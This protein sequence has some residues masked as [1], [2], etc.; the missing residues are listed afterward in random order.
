MYNS[1]GIGAGA[2]TTGVAGVTLLP[3]T[4]GFRAMFVISVIAL[5]IGVSILLVTAAVA[6]KK[7]AQSK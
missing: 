6:F 2:T 5:A 7:R 4:G 3:N 1:I